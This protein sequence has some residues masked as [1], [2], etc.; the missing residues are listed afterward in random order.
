MTGE[1]LTKLRLFFFFSFYL[2]GYFAHCRLVWAVLWLNMKID[3]SCFQL[4]WRWIL[5]LR[6]FSFC[7]E[8]RNTS[9]PTYE[10]S[11]I[12]ARLRTNFCFEIQVKIWDMSALPDANT[13]WPSPRRLTGLFFFLSTG[14]FRNRVCVKISW[15]HLFSRATPAV[16][17]IPAADWQS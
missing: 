6:L 3:S 15:W 13:R 9:I 12:W 14:F 1:E 2:V 16:K 8:P 7:V 4:F 17:I 11:K 10:Y 5:Y